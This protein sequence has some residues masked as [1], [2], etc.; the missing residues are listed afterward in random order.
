MSTS[1]STSIS[2]CDPLGAGS[3]AGWMSNGERVELGV[4]V[5]FLVAPPCA[6][7]PVAAERSGAEKMDE[8]DEV[9]DEVEEEKESLGVGSLAIRRSRASVAA[10]R[11][12][13]VAVVVVV[14]VVVKCFSSS[15]LEVD[16]EDEEDEYRLERLA[17]AAAP[18][19]ASVRVTTSLVEA[20][21]SAPKSIHVVGAV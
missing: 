1:T 3:D 16:E 11:S 13:N 10:A 14:V 7:A 4:R 20:A 12:C 15:S 6:S 17:K 21:R 2:V 8:L 5:N 18:V 9:V 19:S